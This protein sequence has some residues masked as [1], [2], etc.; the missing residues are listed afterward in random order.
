M[1]PAGHAA[2]QVPHPLHSVEFTC[3]TFFSSKYAMALYGQS[4]LQIRQPL[5]YSYITS[6][7]TGSIS[8]TPFAMVASIRAAAALA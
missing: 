6:A 3:D 7:R 4:A 1:A 8:T 5:Q 2:T